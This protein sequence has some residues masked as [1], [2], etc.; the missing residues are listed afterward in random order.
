MPATEG[1]LRLTCE[2]DIALE[3]EPVLYNVKRAK[4]TF[5]TSLHHIIPPAG[6]F[7]SALKPTVASE[8][9][10]RHRVGQLR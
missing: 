5:E 8:R 7:P 2:A 1:F 4:G 10:A 9:E 3:L 6:R